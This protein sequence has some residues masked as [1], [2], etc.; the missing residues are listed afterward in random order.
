LDHSPLEEVFFSAF[1]FD[2]KIVNSDEDVIFEFS[3]SDLEG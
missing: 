1:A 3:N 2:L